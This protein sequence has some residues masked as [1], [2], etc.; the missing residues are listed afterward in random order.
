LQLSVDRVPKLPSAFP[1]INDRMDFS[2]LQTLI[3]RGS[4]AEAISL[5]ENLRWEGIE[6]RATVEQKL[7]DTRRDIRSVDWKAQGEMDNL[8]ERA[9]ERIDAVGISLRT[10]LDEVRLQLE[11]REDFDLKIDW[12]RQL[13][14]LHQKLEDCYLVHVELLHPLI[15]GAIRLI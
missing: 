10:A 7:A 9:R 4:V 12:F 14:I 3:D 5:V 15:G 13:G 6:L 11:R 8:L 2:T 1:N